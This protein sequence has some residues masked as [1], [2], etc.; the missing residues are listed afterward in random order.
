M[1]TTTVL[2]NVDHK[3]L[4]INLHLTAM[5]D[6]KV[7]RTLAYTPEIQDLHKEFPLLFYR[8]P[9]TQTIQL[10]AILGLDKN[11]NLFI[12]DTGWQSRFVPAQLAC[13]PFSIAYHQQDDSA[14]AKPF[15]CFDEQDERVSNTTG[16]SVFLPMGGESAY[17][18]HVKKALQ[19][20]ETGA[21]YDN[22]LFTLAQEM[23]L[24]EPVSVQIKLSDDHQVNFNDYLSI[25]EQAL[26]NLSGDA[27]ARLNQYG[28]LS[29][30]FF[31]LS[32]MSNFQQLIDRK[33]A[34]AAT[35]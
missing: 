35:L 29:L 33:S 21:Q 18:Q 22:T 28:T 9:A 34:Q 24:L 27:L 19:V 31:I 5:A 30:L 1:K 8:D 14:Q 7:N 10:H 25:N 32:S 4:K 16:E 15:L 6:C 3:D 2:N 23:D 13:G 11:E 17:L 20:I 26:A 12:D